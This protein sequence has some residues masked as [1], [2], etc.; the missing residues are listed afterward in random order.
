MTALTKSEMFDLLAE[1][2]GVLETRMEDGVITY[3]SRSLEKMFG[4][5]LPGELEGLPVEA[6]VPDAAKARH[7]DEHRPAYAAH[8]TPRVMGRKMTLHGQR[9]D[10]TVFPVEVFLL[11]RAVGGS[12]IVIGFVVDMTERSLESGL[13]RRVTTP[14]YEAVPPATAQAPAEPATGDSDS[15]TRLRVLPPAP[16]CE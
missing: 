13:Y 8:P 15:G 9:R 4:Y 10:R 2:V 14:V 5:T 11:P 7:R 6:L 16:P 3:A 12:R 1:Y